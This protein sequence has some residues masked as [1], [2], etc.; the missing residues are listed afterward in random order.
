M[1]KKTSRNGTSRTKVA[2][3]AKKISA[4]SKPRSKGEF[5]STIAEHNELSRKQVA[6]IF[7]TMSSVV[8]VA[9]G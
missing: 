6:G 7:D 8:A 4:S 9:D 2:P 3:K 1:A 5:Y